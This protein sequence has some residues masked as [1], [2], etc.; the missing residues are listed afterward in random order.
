MDPSLTRCPLWPASTANQSGPATL[1]YNDT[2]NC[3]QRREVK[4][5]EGSREIAESMR[6][7]SRHN[8]LCRRL[9]QYAPP[10]QVNLWPFDLES[11]ARVTCG[12]GYLCANFSLPR[13]LCFR[14]TPD[15]RDRQTDVKQTSDVRRASSLKLMPPTIG[16][17]LP[18]YYHN[19][20]IGAGT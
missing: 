9:P 2:K 10:L 1:T 5:V 12:V 7:W 6:L 13:P 16:A 20:T 15:A 14:L 4:E 19:I 17:L 8:K 3:Q 11:R 18:Y